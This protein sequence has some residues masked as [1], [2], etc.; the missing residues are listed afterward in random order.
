LRL[1]GHDTFDTWDIEDPYGRGLDDYRRC[2]EDLQARIEEELSSTVGV[3]HLRADIERWRTLLPDAAPTYSQG[4]ASRAAKQNEALL[5]RLANR[6]LNERGLDLGVLLAE[7]DYGGTA[8]EVDRLPLGTATDLLIRLTE[9][10]TQLAAA[11][12]D[13]DALRRIPALRNKATHEELPPDRMRAATSNLLDALDGV[14][15]REDFA[16]L[17]ARAVKSS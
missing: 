9:N 7:I 11:C 17:L 2:A 10:D 5:K 3:S 14:L 8:R 15:G 6:V 16:D 13:S 1:Q 4:I 12:P